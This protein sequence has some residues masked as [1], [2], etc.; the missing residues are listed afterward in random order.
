[1]GESLLSIPADIIFLINSFAEPSKIG[2]SS[3]SISINALSIPRPNN[4]PIKCSIVE[5]FAP[6]SFS[7]VVFN[8]VLVTLLKF[9]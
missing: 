5:T 2:T 7:T 6:N 9:G 8:D 4:A 1:M 3:L